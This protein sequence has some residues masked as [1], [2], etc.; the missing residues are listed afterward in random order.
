MI[1]KTDRGKTMV[2]AIDNVNIQGFDNPI[3]L[4]HYK[5]DDEKYVHAVDHKVDFLISNNTSTAEFF[6]E[7]GIAV[8]LK[9]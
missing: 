9:L 8:L 5:Q 2:I 1:L 6:R 7:N 3:D 4:G